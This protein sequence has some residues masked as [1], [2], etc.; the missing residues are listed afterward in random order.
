MNDNFYPQDEFDE[1]KFNKKIVRVSDLTYVLEEVHSKLNNQ[2]SQKE[3]LENKQYLIPTNQ[4]RLVWIADRFVD[5]DFEKLKERIP[6]M[7]DD[8]RLMVIEDETHGGQT[9]IF[10]L[11]NTDSIPNVIYL[12][13]EDPNRYATTSAVRQYVSDAIG[14]SELEFMSYINSH[15]EIIEKILDVLKQNKTDIATLSNNIS[16]C[17]DS[18]K[19]LSDKVDSNHEEITRHIADLDSR[20]S[21]R[22][23]EVDLKFG[24][25]NETV[26]ANNRDTNKR[27][28][29]L[30]TSVQELSEQIENIQQSV[31]DLGN[32]INESYTE[33]DNKIKGYHPG[34]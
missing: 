30:K 14:H 7:K 4:G 9:S 24:E 21:V 3:R 17:S 31:S 29:S 6:Y 28:N 23:T 26:E 22:E 12:G 27:I 32:R 20:I 5:I 18:I 16:I 13:A 1:S 15:I 33:L 10:K 19:T 2:I 34:T 25:I 8:D 11:Y